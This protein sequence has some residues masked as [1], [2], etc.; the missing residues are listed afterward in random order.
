MFGYIYKKDAAMIAIV[1]CLCLCVGSLPKWGVCSVDPLVI[2]SRA[3][4]LQ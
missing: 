1:L 3:Q 4:L 2:V